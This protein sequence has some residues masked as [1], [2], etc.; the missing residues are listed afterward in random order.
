[1]R[2]A[3]GW[4]YLALNLLLAL[5]L[6]GASWQARV[7]WNDAQA[8]RRDNLSELA[9]LPVPMVLP[10]SR[11]H[12]VVVSDYAD[13]VTKYLFSADRNPAPS[14]DPPKAAEP[15]Q[16]PP[17]PV[18]YGVLGLSSGTKAIMSAK[19]GLASRAVQAG[20]VI[21]EFT[22]GAVDLQGIT[23]VWNGE[24]IFREIEDLMDRSNAATPEGGRSAQVQSAIAP[25]FE[26]PT[27]TAPSGLPQLTCIKG[28]K[29][30]PGTVVGRYKKIS[31]TTPLGPVCSW[32]RVE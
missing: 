7:I 6:G 26:I 16:M 18:V 3:L 27:T 20:D 22:I 23:F 29:S 30:P 8:R 21:N 4:K 1:M 28:D 32:V 31:T 12:G 24:Q 15:R 9:P 17:L 19:A 11:P 10:A 2:D 13:I 5:A 25:L 14:I